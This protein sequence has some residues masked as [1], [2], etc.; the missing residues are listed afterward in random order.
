MQKGEKMC[1][2]TSDKV[3]LMPLG[4][5]RLIQVDR[6]KKKKIIAIVPVLWYLF[7]PIVT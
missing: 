6:L 5:I 1:Y 2:K 4:K 3:M 7:L